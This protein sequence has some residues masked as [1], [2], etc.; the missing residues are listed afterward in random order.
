VFAGG[1]A[2]AGAVQI[3][4]IIVFGEGHETGAVQT[5]LMIVLGDGQFMAGAGAFPAAG[6]AAAVAPNNPD[7]HP[8]SYAYH[9]AP[10][11]TAMVMIPL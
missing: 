9:A 5:P 3:P 6:A 11:I 2:A 1:F 10:A 4:L 8:S 7:N